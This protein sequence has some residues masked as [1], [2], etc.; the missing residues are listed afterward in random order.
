M[1]VPVP[2]PVHFPYNVHIR[3][4]TELLNRKCIPVQSF[5]QCGV[6]IGSERVLWYS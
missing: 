3:M 1:Y 5:L 2:V 6:A 4:Y